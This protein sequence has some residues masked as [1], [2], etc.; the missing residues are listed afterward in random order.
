[1][2]P[3]HKNPSVTNKS[4]SNYSRSATGDT[5]FY[6]KTGRI[7][8]LGKVLN[9]I[10][11]NKGAFRDD[12]IKNRIVS[13]L[14]L[15]SIMNTL[16][17]LIDIEKKGRKDFYTLNSWGRAKIELLA[18]KHAEFMNK[19]GVPTKVKTLFESY[20]EQVK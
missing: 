18:K 12:L 10:Y 8:N 11:K 5:L 15:Q 4:K 7:T 14:G 1:M 16:V 20:L 17:D 9:Y 3:K 6:D 19:Q 2:W 13:N